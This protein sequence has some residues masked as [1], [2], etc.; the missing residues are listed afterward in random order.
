MKLDKNIILIDTNPD[1]GKNFCK[2]LSESTQIEW[3]LIDC[4]SNEGRTHKYINIIR[5][6]KYFIFPLRIFLNRKKIDNIVT[7]QQFYGLIYAFYCRFFP[8]KKKAIITDN[9]IYIQKEK[10]HYRENISPVH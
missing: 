2:A 5:Y 6:F 8:Y 4:I 7:W 9:D 1:E 3:H 10:R